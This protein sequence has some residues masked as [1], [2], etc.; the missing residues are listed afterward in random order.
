M[1]HFCP[2]IG[3]RTLNYLII[4]H[5]SLQRYLMDLSQHCQSSMVLV[6]TE[7]E[8]LYLVFNKF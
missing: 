5:T 6:K 4:S 8:E 2:E 7:H 3:E 1:V